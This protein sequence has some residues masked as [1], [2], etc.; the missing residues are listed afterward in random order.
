MVDEIPLVFSNHGVP[1]SGRVLRG[2]S[3][4]ERRPIVLV[5]GSWLTV[6]EQMPLLY[7]RRLAE[8]GYNAFIFDFTGF[9][10]SR[11]EPRQVE[12][13]SR[14][15]GDLRAA[16]EFL[17]TVGFV[18]AERVGAVGVCAS[19]QNV[20]TA[21]A[22][23]VPIRTF[24]SVAGWY[25]DP[26]SV[27]A[28]YGGAEGVALR[29]AR[30]RDATMKYLKTGDLSIV[31]AY[32]NGNDRAGMFFPLD[33]YAQPDRGAI[34][35]WRNEMSEMTWSHWLTFDGLAA[36]GRVGSPCLFV[37]SDGCV[38]PDHAKQVHASVKGPKELVWMTGNQIDFYDQPQEVNAAM[39]AIDAW[40][41]RTL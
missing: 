37:H 19:A 10:E 23:K 30:A 41:R 9:G 2:G 11:G 40:F 20:L 17:R 1:L 29:M 26:A 34:P 15:I 28:F 3:G 16:V 25:H 7:A 5:A 39:E 38:F 14:K 33:Y 21:L 12:M 35:A 8:A 13:P 32:E 31:P 22:Q 36:A 24:A 27:A 4:F 6:K 18:D